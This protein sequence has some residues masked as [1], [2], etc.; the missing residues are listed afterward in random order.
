MT[1]T[2]SAIWTP[3]MRVR[4]RSA[5]LLVTAATILIAAWPSSAI[6]QSGPYSDVPD[7]AYYA[8]SVSELREAG[9]FDGTA[10]SEFMCP[11]GFCPSEPIDRKTVAVWVV[12]VLDGQDPPHGPSRFDDVD[13][14]L[15]AFWPSFIERMA[16]LG[17]T[18][19]CGDGSGFCPNR[20]MNRAEMA[21]FLSRAFNLPDGPDS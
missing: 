20:H 11:N 16:E 17:V 15:P 21:V 8:E 2:R 14:C 4:L 1:I 18:R 5:V 7:D 3:F 12:R 9:V 13:C 19:G 10:L 6:A